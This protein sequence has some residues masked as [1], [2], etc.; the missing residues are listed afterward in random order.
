[1][2]GHGGLR[3]SVALFDLGQRLRA[4]ADAR[5]VG[6]SAFAPVLPPVD[7]VAVTVTGSGDSAV[8]RATDGVRQVAASGPGA[9]S[10]LN[11]LGV[12]LSSDF[13]TLV[14]ADRETLAHLL[15]LAYAVDSASEC[16]DT[17]AVIGWW[18]QRAD[19]P[20]TGAV[21]KVAAA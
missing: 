18:S 2:L 6:R 21:L 1:R 7:P 15:E 3:M 8:L 5:P 17:A 9:L 4:A 10:A 12:T 20:G 11:E 13:R 16:A 14:V 19:H